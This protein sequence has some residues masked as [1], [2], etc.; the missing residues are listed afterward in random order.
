MNEREERDST[1]LPVEIIEIL[2][3][4][5]ID[6]ETYTLYDYIDVEPL[7]QVLNSEEADLEVRL[8]IEGVDLQITSRGVRDL[9]VPS[10]VESTDAMGESFT[11]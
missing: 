8:T 9:T 6:P 1:P 7:E 11:D 4:H 3:A 2:D 5:G 10:S